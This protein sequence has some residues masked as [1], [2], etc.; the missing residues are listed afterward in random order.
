MFTFGNQPFAL[1]PAVGLLGAGWGAGSEGGWEAEDL[2]TIRG[3][4]RE[5]ETLQGTGA[6][7]A[8]RFQS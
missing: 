1:Q 8:P 6:R 3:M 7:L 4:F 5:E 2:E